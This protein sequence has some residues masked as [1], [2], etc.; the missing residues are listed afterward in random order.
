MAKFDEGKFIDLCY[1]A[2]MDVELWPHV[3]DQFGEAVGARGSL[4]I[5]HDP[6]RTA[7]TMHSARLDEVSEDY[8]GTWWKHD[9]RITRAKLLELKP[10]TIYV[11]AAFFNPEEKQHD[12]FFQDFY[13]KHGLDD[14]AA[15]FS[16]DPH[17]TGIVTISAPRD[18]NKGPFGEQDLVLLRQLAPHVT[19]AFHLAASF[20]VARQHASNLTAGLDMIDVGAITLDQ[21]GKLLSI[22]ASAER[23]IRACFQIVNKTI[24]KGLTHSLQMKL[25]IIVR[26]ALQSRVGSGNYS[27]IF[28]NDQTGNCIH[29][30]A[31]NPK[32][33]D[34]T[35]SILQSPRN[36]ILLVVRDPFKYTGKDIIPDLQEVG[37][38]RAE[39]Y[40]AM[41]IGRG[42]SPRE[43]SVKLGISEQTIRTQMKSLYSKLD[44]NRQAELSYMISKID[45]VK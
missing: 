29:I 45:N 39:A 14:M 38:T 20:N 42:L 10:G 37:L 32:H 31:I 34:T 35:P 5:S 43:A 1:A 27:G 22:N 3:L 7:H 26:D 13:H 6:T 17:G 4:I 28:R 19:R 8:S 25:D 36:T 2:S 18:W 40:A 15:Y 11:D 21:S 24:L 16:S 44:I 41:L 12:P 33:N 23:L 9:S 30:Q